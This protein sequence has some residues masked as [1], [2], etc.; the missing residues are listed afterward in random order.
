MSAN[1]KTFNVKTSIGIIIYKLDQTIYDKFINNLQNI[2]CYD[3]YN[4]DDVKS[5]TNI[6]KLNEYFRYDEHIKF[7]LV[8]R[9]NSLNYIDFIRGKYNI[10]DLT[11]IINMVNYMSTYEIELLK[12]NNFN[13]LWRDLWLKNAYKKKYLDEMKKSN[14][15]F[16]YLKSINF[17]DNL[18]SEYSSTEWEIPK[19]GKNYNETNLNCAIRE[20]KEETSLDKDNYQI[21]KCLEPIHDIFLGTNNKKYRHIF[22]TALY[23]NNINNILTI[24]HSNNEIDCVKWCSWSEI[25]KLIRPYNNSK[26]KILTL[27]FFFIINICNDYK[28]IKLLTI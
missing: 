6:D 17:F 21:I 4:I 10:D 28:N 20:L 8:K 14:I 12:N 26:I 27:L 2:S 19:G 3:I 5:I 7:L 22:Y 23:N 11:S 1:I 25:I 16:D 15:K 9:R 13:K 18:T 24:E